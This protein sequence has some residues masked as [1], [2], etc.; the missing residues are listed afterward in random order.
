MAN[1]LTIPTAG[2][3]FVL[4]D[5]RP[6]PTW[7]RFFQ[8]LGSQ[9]NQTTRDLASTDSGLGT[10]ATTVQK[11]YGSWPYLVPEDGTITLALNLAFE[12]TITKVSTKTNVG[13]A[14]VTVKIDGV[15]LGGTANSAST[16]QQEQAHSSANVAAAG[17][18]VQVT[19]ASTSAD[20]AGLTIAIEGTRV[21]AT[22]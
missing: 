1:D 7:W 5:G 21:L 2:E 20:C 13:T 17:T 12:W 22:T 4:E 15:A 8:R 19:L 10:K 9:F 18:D 11:E 14:T 6:N 16:S 3:T